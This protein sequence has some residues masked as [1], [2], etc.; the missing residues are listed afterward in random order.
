[1][2][3]AV[4][5]H[6]EI[7]D[8]FLSRLADRPSS[9]VIQLRSFSRSRSLTARDTSFIGIGDPVLFDA[10][11]SGCVNCWRAFGITTEFSRDLSGMIPLAFGNTDAIDS[12]RV[13]LVEDMDHL[14][15]PKFVPT[16]LSS[17]SISVRDMIAGQSLYV[18]NADSVISFATATRADTVTGYSLAPFHIAGTQLEMGSYH[19][20]ITAYRAGYSRTTRD[21]FE[22]VWHDMPLSLDNPRD[23]IA[24]MQYVMRDADFEKLSAG[25]NTEEMRKL[26][27]YWKTQDPTPSTAFNER[28]SEFYRRADYA[29]FNF[30]R[31]PRQLDGAMTDR[32]KIYILYGPPTNIQRSFLVGE[33]PMEI[34]TYS[35]NV[36]KIFKFLS[37]GGNE[38]KL[39]EVKPM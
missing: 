27:E 30:A 22:L 13:V 21:E 36:K 18:A 10:N 24:P 33:Q 20:D 16:T 29:Y 5:V 11:S 35:N 8:G 38:F 28:M 39:A 3:Q 23:A 25:S 17:Q 31:N 7:R 19:F 9:R 12:V 1:M 26:F 14:K 37:Q 2:P 6:T 32:G 4:E 15:T 34:W